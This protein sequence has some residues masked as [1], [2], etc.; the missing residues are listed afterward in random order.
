MGE[1]TEKSSVVFA[2]VYIGRNARLWLFRIVFD[3][4]PVSDRIGLGFTYLDETSLFCIQ[5][6]SRGG[7]VDQ[8]NRLL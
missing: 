8:L 7:P 3:V 5:D 6:P 4:S 1:E 2:L